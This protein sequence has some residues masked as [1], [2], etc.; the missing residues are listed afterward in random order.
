MGS[1][2]EVLK[3][4]TIHR[5]WL[6]TRE[7]FRVTLFTQNLTYFFIIACA[8]AVIL[9]GLTHK[10]AMPFTC[11]IILVNYVNIWQMK[12][13]LFKCL[14]VIFWMIIQNAEGF[15]YKTFLCCNLYFKNIIDSLTADIFYHDQVISVCENNKSLYCCSYD[16]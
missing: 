3:R 5:N 9:I 2:F 15:K 6:T 11:T 1:I 10:Y 16:N 13:Q 7:V 14:D 8:F 12:F 4:N